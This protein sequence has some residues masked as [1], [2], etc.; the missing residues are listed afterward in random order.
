MTLI[1]P[2]PK[3]LSKSIKS[4]TRS[5]S[6]DHSESKPSQQQQSDKKSRAGFL[7]VFSST[8]ITIFL[9][10]MGDKTQLA[11][12]LITAESNSPW[13][14]FAGSAF[15]LIATSLLGVLIGRWLAK[16]VSPQTS[17]IAA[18]VLLLFV[19]V[20]LLGEVVCG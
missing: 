18:A 5:K 2:V 3:D 8:F 17:E 13:T 7:A 19:S 12:L 6:K 10:E 14:V 15:A 11:T 20:L 16:R 1:E 4:A 9:A